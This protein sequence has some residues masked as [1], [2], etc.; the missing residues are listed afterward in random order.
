MEAK[1]ELRDRTSWLS[2]DKD[3]YNK[4][5]Y[6]R[7]RCD[8]TRS[9]WD[10]I[11]KQD[12]EAQKQFVFD[13]IKCKPGRV[14]DD[15]L[16]QTRRVETISKDTERGQW[17]SYHEA[18]QKDSKAIVDEK[19]AFG[20][21]VSRR[22]RGLPPDSKIEYPW[23]QEVAYT[24]STWESTRQATDIDEAPRDADP[25]KAE[26]DMQAFNARF[27][28]IAHVASS[29]TARA[30]LDATTPAPRPSNDVAKSKAAIVPLR[31]SHSMFDKAK[32]EW[33]GV[34]ERSSRSDVTRGSKFELDLKEIKSEAEALDDANLTI[35]NKFLGGTSLSDTDLRSAG[36]NTSALVALIRSGNKK[37]TMI[38]GWL[39]FKE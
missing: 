29:S 25:E 26:E 18:T 23:N 35:E 19:L 15:V 10:I 32:R 21:L 24:T 2:E 30:E 39:N 33:D 17:M 28:D 36:Q 16:K 13:V 38:R 7:S 12:V 3:V 4:F 14:P 8:A 22:I 1:Q 31:K 20:T 34:L 5:H 9:A 37:T 27:D 6:R 11:S